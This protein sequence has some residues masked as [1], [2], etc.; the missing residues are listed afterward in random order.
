MYRMNRRGRTKGFTLV[1]LMISM[2]FIGSLLVMISLIIILIMG[3]YNKGLTLKEVNQVSRTVVRDMQQSV[4]SVDAFGLQYEDRTSEEM[5]TGQSL[6]DIWGTSADYYENEAGGRLCTGS[7]S[8]AWNTGAALKSY[9]PRLVDYNSAAGALEYEGGKIQFMTTSSG[10]PTPVRFVKKKDPGKQL[11]HPKVDALTDQ[12]RMLGD[13]DEFMN[14][15]GAGNNELVL[16]DFSIETRSDIDVSTTDLTAVSTFYYIKMVLGTQAGDEGLIEGDVRCKP[17]A[18]ATYNQGEYC[19][20]NKI[21][22][23]AR[24]GGIGR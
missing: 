19:A 12:D 17:P 21:D 1:E 11:C 24:T 16:Y 18:D 2:A 23:V 8:Y 15:F 10:N 14:V 22:F 9:N 13:A 4:A 6:E 5:T 20:V 3:L 7:Y